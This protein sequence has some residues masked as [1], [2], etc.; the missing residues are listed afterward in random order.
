M[1]WDIDIDLNVCSM[2]EHI[3]EIERMIRTIKECYHAML[4]GLPYRKIPRL[5]IDYAIQHVV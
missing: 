2:Q 3:P 5:M 1:L 4:N